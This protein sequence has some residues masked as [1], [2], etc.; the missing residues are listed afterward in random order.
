MWASI[1]TLTGLSPVFAQV[2]QEVSGTVDRELVV[3]TNPSQVTLERTQPVKLTEAIE[4]AGR[5]NRDLVQARLNLERAR[6][7]LREAEAARLPTVTTT[8]EYN[9]ND[10][11][12]AR[13]GNVASP[14]P[15]NS[16]TISQPLTGTVGIN[17]NLFTGGGV[18]ANV[19]AAEN[20][21]RIAEAELNRILQTIRLQITTAYYNLQSA[22]ETVRIR[23][24]SVENNE[25]SLKDAQAQERAGTGTKFDVLQAEVS[26]A[27]AKQEL[28]TAQANQLIARREIARL[29]E[30]PARVDFTAAD[31]IKPEAEWKLSREES[32]VLALRNRAELDIRKLER[33]VARNRATA[34]LSS[35]APQVSVFANY[36]LVDNL[37]TAG[38]F[39]MGYRLGAR[40]QM[41]LFDGGAAAARSDQSTVEKAIAESRFE[42]DANQIRFDVE[43]AFLNLQAR[44]QQITTTGKALEQAIEALRLARLRFSA[45]VGTQ[46]E[47]IRA[48]EEVTRADVNRLQS[49][50]GYNQSLAEL[51]R[52]VS[53][54]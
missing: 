14:F 1:F 50:I 37:S 53:G 4:L 32:I 15:N 48:E 7:V 13:L 38:G 30:Y 2:G 6:A 3:P 11:A 42:Q 49:I 31:E 40:L 23:Q 12:N 8:V 16:G 51:Q 33:E 47:V 52:A 19:R 35:L 34:A 21:L 20:S 24:K 18:E 39:A 25:R 43:Q 44:R 41:N 36:D 54:L 9:L 46:L 29:L 10:S 22:D 45:G 5:T 28:F 26:L 27:N 17:Y